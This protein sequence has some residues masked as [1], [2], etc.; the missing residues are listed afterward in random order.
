MHTCACTHAEYMKTIVILRKC[1]LFFLVFRMNYIW[2]QF[3]SVAQSCPTLPPHEGGQARQASLSITNSQSLLKLMSIELVMLSSHL[4]L[5]CP[6]RLLPP[7]PPSIKVFSN[8]YLVSGMFKSLKITF[9]TVHSL[10]HEIGH[11][12]T[13][14]NAKI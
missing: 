12:N 13:F 14:F 10:S 7:I 4:I 11:L 3:S 1:P 2:I 9:V 6:L 5:C 8:E